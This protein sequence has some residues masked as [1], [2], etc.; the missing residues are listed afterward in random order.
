[1]L[2][3]NS[4]FSPERAFESN[5]H[6]QCSNGKGKYQSKGP[7]SSLDDVQNLEPLIFD[8]EEFEI[9]DERDEVCNLCF[10]MNKHKIEYDY[11]Y[12]V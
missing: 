12:N 8:L 7:W 10:Q 11:S 1:M 5:Y 9:R 4:A 3:H 2:F 6:C